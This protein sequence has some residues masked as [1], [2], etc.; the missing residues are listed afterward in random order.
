MQNGSLDDYC[1]PQKVFWVGSIIK[2]YD[3]GEYSV[4][5]E[6]WTSTSDWFR[7][8]TSPTR[9]LKIRSMAKVNTGW[10]NLEVTRLNTFSLSTPILITKNK[11]FTQKKKLDIT[12]TWNDIKSAIPM[13]RFNKK[14]FPIFYYGV[15]ILN[16]FGVYFLYYYTG[17]FFFSSLFCFTHLRSCTPSSP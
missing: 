8:D 16:T 2:F 1:L 5:R 4:A 13:V 15:C 6:L 3:A 9:I 7:G 11:I 17:V 14:I 10:M 12:T